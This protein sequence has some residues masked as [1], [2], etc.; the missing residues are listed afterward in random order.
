MRG[1]L[2]PVNR[3]INHAGPWNVVKLGSN[4][5]EENVESSVEVET[6]DEHT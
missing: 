5:G 6:G 3:M 1:E 2:E 4:V